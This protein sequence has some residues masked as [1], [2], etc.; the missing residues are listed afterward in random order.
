MLEVKIILGS[1]KVTR[2]RAGQ[3][4]S[5]FGPQYDIFRML[6]N[7]CALKRVI[8]VEKIME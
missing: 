2:L 4:L 8:N 3:I 1:R 6:T 7:E 5:A